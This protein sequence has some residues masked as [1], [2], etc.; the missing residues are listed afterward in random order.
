[1]VDAT[2]IAQEH[3]VLLIAGPTASGKSALAMATA[4]AASGAGCRTGRDCVIVN[5][6]SMQV[7]GD[8][9]VLTARP[10][11]EDE[12]RV[13][14]CLFGHVD[15]SERYSVGAWVRAVTPVLA[16][17]RAARRGVIIV[18]GTG[19]YFSALTE[20]LAEIPDISVQT[21]NGVQAKVDAFGGDVHA[22][23]RGLYD[24]AMAVDGAATA[25]VEP[26]DTH[27]LLRIVQVWEQTG[28]ALSDWRAATRPVLPA[29]AWRGVVVCPER[30]QLYDRINRRAA[31]IV[32]QGGVGEVDALLARGL[33]PDLPVMKALG[34]PQLADMLRGR[35]SRSDALAALQRDT[36]RYAKRQMTWMRGRMAG[37]TRLDGGE[38][39]TQ[40]RAWAAW[41]AP[42]N[43]A[44]GA[45]GKS[46]ADQSHALGHSE[47]FGPP[48]ALH[49]PNS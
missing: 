2:M 13:A 37:W 19:L 26:G 45:S 33:D 49:Q 27:R 29:S 16:A 7:Y 35:A 40:D 47:A 32:D 18:G 28:R 11:R 21:R 31:Q 12:A 34:V 39:D 10:S 41:H 23:A 17:S 4:L 5:A 9:R 48:T 8:L 42:V 6:D 20:G 3:P 46:A 24:W 30:D 1:M 38:A 36:R 22:K 43:P 14:H 44:C 15:G 25:G